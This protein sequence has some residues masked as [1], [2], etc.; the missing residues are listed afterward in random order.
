[1]NAATSGES[2]PDGLRQPP[3]NFTVLPPVIHGRSQLQ[4]SMSV[5]SEPRLG[6]DV[7]L[8]VSEDLDHGEEEAG[9]S[10]PPQVTAGNR[11]NA[12]L[13]WKSATE[14]IISRLHQV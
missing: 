13:Y 6:G 1:M 7:V 9:R 2:F 10:D 14:T 3:V 12:R 5:D 4:T 8:T 11:G